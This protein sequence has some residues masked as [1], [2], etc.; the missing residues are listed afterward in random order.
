MRG[1]G[2]GKKVVRNKG[3]ADFMFIFFTLG[4]KFEYFLNAFV[5]KSFM[6]VGVILTGDP[7]AL[8]PSVTTA[9]CPR[10]TFAASW[11]GRC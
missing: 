9:S 11:T 3:K 8:K 5:R 7:T 10:P 4:M 1:V 2:I 6:K